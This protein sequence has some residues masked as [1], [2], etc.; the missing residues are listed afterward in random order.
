M[1]SRDKNKSQAIPT[2]MANKNMKKYSTISN[3]GS[4]N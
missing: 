3:Y 2:E 1:N 4:S